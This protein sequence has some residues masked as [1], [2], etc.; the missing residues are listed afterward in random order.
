M[1]VASVVEFQVGGSLGHSANDPLTPQSSVDTVSP[2]GPALVLKFHKQKTV[3][4]PLVFMFLF[5]F[6]LKVG[7]HML[8]G[9]LLHDGMNVPT[10]T[11]SASCGQRVADLSTVR[12]ETHSE[13]IPRARKIEFESCKQKHGQ[14]LNFRRKN[15]GIIRPTG[16]FFRN[17]FELI[18]LA[19]LRVLKLF[20]F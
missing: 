19:G 8:P 6:L 1:R 5:R 15:G 4:P 13:L 17:M 20:F 7:V 14:I 16:I 18:H 10:G 9:N 11:G 2:V 12:A 3:N